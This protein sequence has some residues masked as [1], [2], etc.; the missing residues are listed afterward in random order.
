MRSEQAGIFAAA[1][2][3]RES[4]GIDLESI[5]RT[6]KINPRYLRA[7]ERGEFEVLPGGA[8]D[9][10]FI[11]QYARAFDFDEQR[12]LIAYRQMQEPPGAASEPEPAQRFTAAGV[13]K[14]LGGFLSG[15][16]A[17]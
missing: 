4:R 14:R 17:R 8:Y 15:A 6:T 9:I 12:L 10:S 7:I 13:L 11:R 5:G 2:A 16:L 1:A 3:V